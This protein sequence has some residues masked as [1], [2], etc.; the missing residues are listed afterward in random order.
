M[1]QSNRCF[2][3]RIHMFFSWDEDRS[4]QIFMQVRTTDPCE[5]NCHF[6]LMWLY[7]RYFH[8]FDTNVFRC[9]PASCFHCS[10][11]IIS[12]FSQFSAFFSGNFIPQIVN[13]FLLFVKEKLKMKKSSPLIAPSYFFLIREDSNLHPTIQPRTRR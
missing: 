4:I 8:F 5:L 12:L 6:Y 3:T 7:F 11:L 9:M 10:H 13:V 2:L 1:S